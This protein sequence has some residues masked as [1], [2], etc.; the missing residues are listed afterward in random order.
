MWVAMEEKISK[1]KIKIIDNTDLRNEIEQNTDLISQI[2][3]AIKFDRPALKS[4]K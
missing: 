3:L 2:D 1:S 4:T